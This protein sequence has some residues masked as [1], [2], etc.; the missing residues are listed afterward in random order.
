MLEKLLY[1][2]LEEK[3]NELTSPLAH[4]KNTQCFTSQSNVRTAEIQYFQD[5]T[6]WSQLK[7]FGQGE[8]RQRGTPTSDA[9]DQISW[10]L[11]P[12][13]SELASACVRS[14]KVPQQRWQYD[15]MAGESEG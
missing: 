8:C 4:I 14:D 12:D 3:T 1:K 5:E 13:K 15:A 10:A 9:I 6:S 2:K 7:G 11:H